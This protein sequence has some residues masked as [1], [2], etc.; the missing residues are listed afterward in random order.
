[1]T[2]IPM[3]QDS[4]AVGRNVTATEIPIDAPQLILS[5]PQLHFSFE[6]LYETG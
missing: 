4:T 3:V 2:A 6:G 5:S 1:M